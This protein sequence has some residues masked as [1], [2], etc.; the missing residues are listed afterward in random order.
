MASNEEENALPM[1]RGPAQGPAA[2]R[3]K[4]DKDEEEDTEEEVD[5]KCTP[6]ENAGNKVERERTYQRK[7]ILRNQKN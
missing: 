4:P 7:S 2:K 6:E 1:K 5:A 3:A